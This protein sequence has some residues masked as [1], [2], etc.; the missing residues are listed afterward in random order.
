[1]TVALIVD[2][3]VRDSMEPKNLVRE[4]RCC[5]TSAELAE[6]C[7]P[8]LHFT[9]LVLLLLLLELHTWLLHFVILGIDHMIG[10]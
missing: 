1:M 7:I 9:S 4:T 5:S 10:E 8:S 3:G 6:L 2:V